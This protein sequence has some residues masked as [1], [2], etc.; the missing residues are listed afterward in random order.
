MPLSDNIS[1]DENG[2]YIPQ[3]WLD[4][5]GEGNYTPITAGRMNHIEQ[6]I[7]GLSEAW[8]SQSQTVENGWHVRR[9][10]DGWADCWRI[11]E[12]TKQSNFMFVTSNLPVAKI[13]DEVKINAD[14]F[15]EADSETEVCSPY[16]THGA[17]SCY[18]RSGSYSQA[19]AKIKVYWDLKMRWK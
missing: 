16:L 17:V 2:I 1:F 11:Q 12:A 14:A 13:D 19:G 15:V 5:T 7:L 10:P 4:G 9:Y 18:V 8:D 6:G 3:T